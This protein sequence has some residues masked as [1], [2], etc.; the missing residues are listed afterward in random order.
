MKKRFHMPGS[1]D[2]GPAT[3][4]KFME[5]VKNGGAERITKD[6]VFKVLKAMSRKNRARKLRKCY[7][8]LRKEVYTRKNHMDYSYEAVIAEMGKHLHMSRATIERAIYGG[9]G[10]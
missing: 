5:A 8:I 1:L 6:N 7:E 4:S 9:K 3:D 2:S 10:K